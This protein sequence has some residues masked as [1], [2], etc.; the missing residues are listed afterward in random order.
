M[1]QY[2]FIM[3]FMV[4]NV[5]AVD[6]DEIAVS[7]PLQS[8]NDR[9]TIPPVTRINTRQVLRE[10]HN[11]AIHERLAVL[12]HNTRHIPALK[13]TV[14]VLV[15]LVLLFAMREIYQVVKNPALS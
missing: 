8:M 1:K 4:L 9:L 3:I 7:I 15:V 12:E 13:G 6:G 2:A 5:I 11:N 14:Q 10:L